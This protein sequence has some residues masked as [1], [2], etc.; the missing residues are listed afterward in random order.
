MV[1]VILQNQSEMAVRCSL[2]SRVPDRIFI[3]RSPSKR[4]PD[5]LPTM[6]ESLQKELF[7]NAYLQAVSATAGF[8]SYRPMP[9]IDKSD[10]VIAA[11][12]PKQTVRSPKV[13]VQLKCT[14][15][16]VLN[17]D[18]LAF[19]VDLET[20]DNLRDPAHMVPK[21]LV[22]VIVPRIVNDWVR[23]SE[24]NLQLHHCG[25][26]LSIR[27]WPESE[28]K[29]GETV[30]ISRSQQFTVEALLRMMERLGAGEMP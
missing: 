2:E 24:E 9:D 5:Q 12:G 25:Y 13:E 16:D 11:P 30:H 20:Y 6:D 21:I 27:G 26:W 8:Q 17:D 18:Q 19:F 7:S 15:R 22:V 10:W 29:S 14:S 23:H 1:G 3:I 28:N 4:I